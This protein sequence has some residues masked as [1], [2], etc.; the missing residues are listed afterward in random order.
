MNSRLQALS[1]SQQPAGSK[2]QP[3]TNLLSKKLFSSKNSSASPEEQQMQNMR[4]AHDNIRRLVG[5]VAQ[6]MVEIDEWDGRAPVTVADEEQ[7]AGDIGGFLEGFLEEVLV[8]VEA[9]EV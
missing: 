9:E 3:T 6:A 4:N 7:R 5:V 8:R 1:T 2:Q